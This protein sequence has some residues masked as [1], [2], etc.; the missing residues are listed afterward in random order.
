MLGF[1][2]YSPGDNTTLIL[3]FST[4]YL[5]FNLWNNTMGINYATESEVGKK[6]GIYFT[7]AIPL[8]QIGNLFLNMQQNF[9]REDTLVYGNRNEFILRAGL[10]KRF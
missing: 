1:T 10:S 4:G 5:F 2:N 9:Y 8:W 6:T 7:S 3:D